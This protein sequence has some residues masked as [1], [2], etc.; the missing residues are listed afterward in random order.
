MYQKRRHL[1]D[2][3]EHGIRR[4]C[5]T[6]MCQYFDNVLTSVIVDNHS[7]KEYRCIAYWLLREEV[8][9]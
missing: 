7:E 8:V 4:G 6:E 5:I 9:G 1:I 3:E 2:D